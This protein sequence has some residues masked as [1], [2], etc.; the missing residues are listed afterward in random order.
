M[1]RRM[2]QFGS[3]QEEISKGKNLGRKIGKAEQGREQTVRR[4]MLNL[5]VEFLANGRAKDRMHVVI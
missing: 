2:I 3:Q 4:D 1:R 5:T